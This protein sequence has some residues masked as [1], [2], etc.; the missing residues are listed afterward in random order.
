MGG[1]HPLGERDERIR[2]SFEE[3]ISR[4][5]M[6]RVGVV[7]D[8]ITGLT[9]ALGAA[10]GGADV[11]LFG[12]TEPMGGLASPLDDGWLFDRA[13]V[14]WPRH[15]P[16]DRLLRKMKVRMPLRR[17]PFD[18]MA[19][20]R[21]DTRTPLPNF[22][23]LLKR[24]QGPM[25][26]E[27]V[28]LIK[29]ARKGD[30]TG[31]SETAM[32]AAS[33]LNILLHL[34]PTPTLGAVSTLNRHPPMAPSDGWVGASGRLIAACLQTD[35]NFQM[36]GAVTGFRRDS[37]G[38]IDGVKR[39]GR[40]MP[41]DGVVIAH[42]GEQRTVHGRYLGLSGQFLRPHSVLWDADRDVFAIDLARIMPN[43]VPSQLQGGATLLH[44]VAF[45][46]ASTAAERIESFL[47]AQ[48]A[49]WRSGIESDHTIPALGIP[50]ATERDDE[51]NLLYATPSNALEVG[52]R[53][54]QS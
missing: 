19:V 22:T 24:P 36:D 30:S 27:W 21:N 54:G 37:K 44:C 26:V 41:V 42:P 8:G 12:K 2:S 32:D 51:K 45:G 5:Y 49:G 29:A 23:G 38:R 9:A 28:E 43:R 52:R 34:D 15:G 39:K 13:P 7:G 47:D 25:A 10:R 31:L 33:L 14:V 3:E 1:F 40:V 53:A 48:C 46:E 4:R 17:I 20:I 6:R 11:V 18:Q 50:V 16:L 35:V